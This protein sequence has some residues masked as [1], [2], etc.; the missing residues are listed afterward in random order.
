MACDYLSLLSCEVNHF[1]EGTPGNNE[2]YIQCQSHTN[3]VKLSDILMPV[4]EIW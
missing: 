4:T 1:S 2:D 3:L